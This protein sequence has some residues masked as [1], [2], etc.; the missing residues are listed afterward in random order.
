MEYP[1]TLFGLP[2]STIAMGAIYALKITLWQKY[3]YIFYNLARGK[4]KMLLRGFKL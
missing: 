2:F 3:D 1:P 4:L